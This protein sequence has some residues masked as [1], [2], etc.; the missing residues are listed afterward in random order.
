[1]PRSAPSVVLRANDR[2]TEEMVMRT[3]LMSPQ[4]AIATYAEDMTLRA[5]IETTGAERRR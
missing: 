2:S 3:G 5:T 4:Q 1:L